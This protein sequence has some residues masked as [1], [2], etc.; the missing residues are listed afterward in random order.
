MTK[1][2]KVYLLVL[3]A[4]VCA[5]CAL[6]AGCKVGRPGREELLAGYDTCVVYYSNGGLF[7]ES[8]PV[9]EFYFKNN[10]DT[11]DVYFFDIQKDTSMKVARSGY[12]L[13]GWYLPATYPDGEHEGEVMYTYTYTD[14]A[15]K[16]QT[17]PVYPVVNEDGVVIKDK[18]TA[19]PVFAR[20]GV[21]EQILEREVA[22]VPS[23]TKLDNSYKIAE[24]T[25]MVVCAQWIPSLKVVYKLACAP[26]EEFTA[27]GKKYKHGDVI[28]STDFG[29]DNAFMPQTTSPLKFDDASFV[30]SYMDESLNTDLTLIP[31]PEAP[32]GERPESPVVWSRYISGAGWNIVSTDN[33]VS[34]MFAS[35]VTSNKYYILNDID[36]SKLTSGIAL[37][38]VSNV[39]AK[40]TIACDG[41][42]KTISNLKFTASRVTQDAT[43]SI[44][45]KLGK[46]FS[47]SGLTLQNVSIEAG[48]SGKAYFY[49]VCNGA[50]ENLPAKNLDLKIE[51]LTAKVTV[52]KPL[53]PDNPNYIY[54]AQNDDK[55]N[56]LFGYG[57]D[58]N[59]KAKYTGLYVTGDSLEII[60]K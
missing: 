15:G 45:G 57:S 16:E 34:R 4:T 46:D 40:I 51:G 28:F 52:S 17:V 31:R 41:G 11:D 24:G 53:N 26:D 18:K 50:D 42:N 47:V 43:I 21:E 48:T 54:N 14:D 36:C 10:P 1:K 55:S 58:A 44:F 12:D 49:A 32:E 5:A 19:R 13:V 29:N 56:W 8:V 7:D 33:D 23:D 35:V 30:R 59:F 37:K 3:I 22:V 25:N 60:N 38:T 39:T 20:E 6:A 2:I 27:G 9:A